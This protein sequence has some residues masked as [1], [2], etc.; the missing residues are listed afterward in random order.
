VAEFKTI[1]AVK[2]KHTDLWYVHTRSVWWPF[3]MRNW[4]GYGYDPEDALK[5]HRRDLAKKLQKVVHYY[6]DE[7]LNEKI[8]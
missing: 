4:N 2:S 6:T 7:E 3:W 5:A 8:S 1:K